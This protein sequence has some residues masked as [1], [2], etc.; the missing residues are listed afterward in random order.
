MMIEAHATLEW[1]G[2]GSLTTSI[3]PR[4]IRETSVV[5]LVES[6]GRTGFL[7]QFPIVVSVLEDGYRLLAGHHR[8]EAARRREIE[9]IPA[10]LY[11]DLTS[12]DEWRIAV[13]TNRA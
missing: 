11:S 1:I 5:R 3:Q 6:M 12:D 8:V 4:S 13:E 7:P 10:L 2:L 9:R